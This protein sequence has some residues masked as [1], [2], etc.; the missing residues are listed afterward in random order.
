MRK[1]LFLIC[2]LVLPVVLSSCT[3][4]PEVRYA[5]FP[6]PRIPALDPDLS[7]KADP[8]ATCQQYLTPLLASQD[9][10]NLVCGEKTPSSTLIT[11]P[12]IPATKISPQP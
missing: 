12:A 6:R 2:V 3:L 9:E 8:V 1:L 4:A 10:L 11:P 5:A 7:D